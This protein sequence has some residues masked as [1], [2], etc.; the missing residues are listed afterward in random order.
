ML[1]DRSSVQ[2]GPYN[3]RRDG[4]KVEDTKSAYGSPLCY[5]PICLKWGWSIRCSSPGSRLSQS[6]TDPSE[7]SIPAGRGFPRVRFIALSSCRLGEM[8]VSA[9][10]LSERNG[11][12]ALFSSVGS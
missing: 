12:E 10:Q 6:V 4:C 11:L 9:F 8:Y 1:F 7:Y 5:N 2:P 3:P